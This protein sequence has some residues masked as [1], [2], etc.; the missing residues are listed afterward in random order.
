VADGSSS[1]HEC[2]LS[3]GQL[4]RSAT[5]R[6]EGEGLGETGFDGRGYDRIGAMQQEI[7]GVTGGLL[8]GAVVS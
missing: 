3:H 1:V 2:V 4:R 5:R 6:R 8:L 7:G